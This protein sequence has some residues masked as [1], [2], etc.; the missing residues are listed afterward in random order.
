[1]VP[2]PFSRAG[3][4]T[5]ISTHLI[6]VIECNSLARGLCHDVSLLI[7]CAAKR[8]DSE[9]I[10]PSLRSTSVQSR[11]YRTCWE[12]HVRK[13]LT[14]LAFGYMSNAQSKLVQ[15]VEELNLSGLVVHKIL[16]PGQKAYFYRAL[17]SLPPRWAHLRYGKLKAGGSS[18]ARLLNVNY[19]FILQ[20]QP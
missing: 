19:H 11:E 13:L 16:L 12:P 2:Y 14:Q 5:Y 20:S 15:M 8:W 1:M 10:W 17:W 9:S 18:N 4:K 3:W 6:Q 7:R